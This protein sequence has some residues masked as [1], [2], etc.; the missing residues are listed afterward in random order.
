VAVEVAN[1]SMS[2]SNAFERDRETSA[3]QIRV[4]ARPLNADVWRAKNA[5]A[6]FKR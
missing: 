1:K 3:T 4:L 5:V 2:F 6:S